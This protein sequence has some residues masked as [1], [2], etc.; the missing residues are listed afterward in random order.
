MSGAR[1][2]GK[3]GVVTGAASGLGRATA[4]G[5]AAEGA[6]L[7]LLDRD[8]AGL[9][10]TRAECPGAIALPIDVTSGADMARAAE[11]AKALGRVDLLAT[12]AGILGPTKP[13]HEVSEDEW[14]QLFDVNVKGTWLAIRAFLPQMLEAK[15]GSIVT[16][17]SGAGLTGN[18]TMP[19]YSAS[20]GAVVLL[21][22][23][24]ATTHAA[25]GIR[26]NTVCPGPIDTPMLRDTFAKAGD[27][28]AERERFFRARN[29]MQRFGEA[30]EVAA[31][32]LFLLSDAAGYING[33]ALPIDGGK[34][35]G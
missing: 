16:F 31:T 17:S 12:A 5:L 26:C 1:F 15:S 23:S 18:A 13:I 33:V 14:D 32:V 24:I 2:V 28:A 9:E 22:K 11:A 10:A 27:G 21:T 29:P 30:E 20:K 34:L 4:R 6:R 35:A 25:Q 7:L 19:A 8:A 3:V